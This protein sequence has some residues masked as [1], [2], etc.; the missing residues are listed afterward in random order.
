MAYTTACTTV[1][2]V[3]YTRRTQW[4]L[5][6][7]SAF[8]WIRCHI[9]Y[10]ALLSPFHCSG[11][12]VVFVATR[13][14]SNSHRS[15]HRSKLSYEADQFDVKIGCSRARANFDL[16]LGC[17][18]L[19]FVPPLSPFHFPFFQSYLLSFTFVY[20]YSLYLLLPWRSV[21]I[22][23]PF[24]RKTWD[25]HTIQIPVVMPVGISIPTATFMAIRELVGL[26]FNV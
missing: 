22:P 4:S 1:Q 20:I 18:P 17:H 23:A 7:W 13:L 26:Q 2:A 15:G 10:S 3:M 24:V 5:F 25:A 11:E 8:S 21:P 19:L 16:K 6:R 12:F 9:K 14:L